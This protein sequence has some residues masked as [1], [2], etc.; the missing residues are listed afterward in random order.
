MTYQ[1]TAGGNGNAFDAFK[2]PLLQSVNQPNVLKELISSDKPVS[3]IAPILL[4]FKDKQE[5]T[6]FSKCV[7][8]C[9]THHIYEKA[10]GIW[11]TQM[12]RSGVDHAQAN[13]LVDAITGLRYQPDNN[14]GGNH[15]KEKRNK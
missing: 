10:K 7:T 3:Q 6:L 2:A 14:K 15:D 13:L 4:K 11:L 5:A 9:E 1:Q 12:C 8:K